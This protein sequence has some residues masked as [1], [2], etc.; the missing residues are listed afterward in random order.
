LKKCPNCGY[1]NCDVVDRCLKCRVDTQTY[2][3]EVKLSPHREPRKDHPRHLVGLKDGEVLLVGVPERTFG[4]CC[5]PYYPAKSCSETILDKE[6]GLV[7]TARPDYLLLQT[8]EQ[9]MT[10][11][12]KYWRPLTEAA[13]QVGASIIPIDE[14]ALDGFPDLVHDMSLRAPELVIFNAFYWLLAEMYG[15]L[16]HGLSLDTRSLVQASKFYERFPNLRRRVRL[17]SLHLEELCAPHVYEDDCS[18]ESEEYIR[19]FRGLTSRI[20]S[21]SEALSSV[22]SWIQQN[23]ICFASDMKYFDNPVNTSRELHWAEIIKD[24][25]GKESD[26]RL[27]LIADERHLKP[28]SVLKRQLGLFNISYRAETLSW[29]ALCPECEART[30]KQTKRL[31]PT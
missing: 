29:D 22:N 1:R 3:V 5:P 4:V 19:R 27:M 20:E 28:D 21:L 14:S 17:E 13:K 30:G 8:T 18:K 6:I 16:T 10:K 15:K 12:A 9:E 24:F 25:L 7:E 31:R 2:A 26:S 11:H 23:N